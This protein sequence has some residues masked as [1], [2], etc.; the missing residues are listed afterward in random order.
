MGC[1]CEA[2]TTAQ[3]SLEAAQS[4]ILFY[5][6]STGFY[7]TLEKSPHKIPL[8][9]SCGQ[10]PLPPEWILPSC[11]NP[12]SP[13]LQL[14]FSRAKLQGSLPLGSNSLNTRLPSPALLLRCP[15]K[16]GGRPWCVGRVRRKDVTIHPCQ[17]A[18]E[19]CGSTHCCHVLHLQPPAS[20]AARA[21]LSCAAPT[22]VT[23][24]FPAPAKLPGW[25]AELKVS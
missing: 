17:V 23:V 24:A 8:P 5:T 25:R 15:R 22:P 1:S 13:A 20:S 3:N 19:S 21:H 12:G 10:N 11:P 7:F 4:K 2:A 18:G 6:T 14:H 16:D 9:C